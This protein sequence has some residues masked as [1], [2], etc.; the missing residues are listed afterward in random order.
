M[1]KRRTDSGQVVTEYVI[2]LVMVVLIAL[3][4]TALNKAVARQG[5][6]MVRVAAYN[7]P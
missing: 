4:L 5:E 7:V 6:R 3:S 2:M 1:R